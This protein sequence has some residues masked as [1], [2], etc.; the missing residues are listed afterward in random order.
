MANPYNDSLSRRI[1]GNGILLLG[2]L[3]VTW[4]SGCIHSGQRNG[5]GRGGALELMPRFTSEMTG[6]I[7]GLLNNSNAF[8]SEFTMWLGDPSQ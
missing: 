5:F 8:S 4:T 7:A 1:L 3:L 2:V 6:G